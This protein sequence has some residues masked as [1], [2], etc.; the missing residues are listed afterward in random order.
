M[1]YTKSKKIDFAVILGI[2]RKPLEELFLKII[3]NG[4]HFNLLIAA[5][6]T[7]VK[8]QQGSLSLVYLFIYLVLL[9]IEQSRR[10][11]LHLLE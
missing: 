1:I 9:K 7:N 10:N 8:F 5:R 11:K 3:Y 2:S 6:K 4:Q